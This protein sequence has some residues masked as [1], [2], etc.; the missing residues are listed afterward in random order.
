M[1]VC[2]QIV[3][4]YFEKNITI[5]TMILMLLKMIEIS[6]RLNCSSTKNECRLKLRF[7]FD[8]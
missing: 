5:K 2:M 8:T 1:D 4:M 6:K 7:K 3:I